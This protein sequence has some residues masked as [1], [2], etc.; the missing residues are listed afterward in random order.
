ME[1]KA[2]ITLPQSAKITP[3]K[4]GRNQTKGY[5]G[6]CIHQ[7]RTTDVKLPSA[8]LLLI[9][10]TQTVVITSQ[11]TQYSSSGISHPL[12]GLVLLMW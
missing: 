2:E 8:G 7:Q 11:L 12:T 5:Y 4:A 1:K 10:K 9:H 3:Q 6:K